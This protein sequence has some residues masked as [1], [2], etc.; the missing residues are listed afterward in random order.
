ML[1]ELLYR[2]GQLL[3]VG[4]ELSVVMYTGLFVGLTSCTLSTVHLLCLLCLLPVR[5]TRL[6]LVSLDRTTLMASI[7]L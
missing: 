7:F 1:Y 3:G 4:E 2:L 6:L 5:V